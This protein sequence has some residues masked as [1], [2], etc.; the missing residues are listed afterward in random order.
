MSNIPNMY[1]MSK[2]KKRQCRRAFYS[3]F[4]LTLCLLMMGI[5]FLT[6]DYNTRNMMVGDS[7][8][9]FG[10]SM[11]EEGSITV[12]T[13]G[14]KTE[15]AITDEIRQWTARAWNILPARWR[16][17]TLLNQAEKAIVPVLF[18]RLG[19]WFADYKEDYSTVF[20]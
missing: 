14:N 15:Y 2:T 12:T 10:Y 4:I 6:A 1:H 16:A 11:E 13:M 9:E 20:V 3:T 18:D 5:G 17:T 7:S 8:L 19:K